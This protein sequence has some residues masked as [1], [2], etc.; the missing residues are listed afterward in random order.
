MTNLDAVKATPRKSTRTKTPT[1]PRKS[2]RTPK[3]KT[4]AV[5][6]RRSA[7]SKK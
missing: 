4:R 5:S 2:T 1:T 6:P 7:R 3:P